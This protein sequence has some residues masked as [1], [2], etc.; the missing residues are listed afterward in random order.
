[1]N[2]NRHAQVERVQQLPWRRLE[3]EEVPGYAVG[4]DG[5]LL[6]C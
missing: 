1:M 4:A 6:Y 3:V 2:N 5:Q